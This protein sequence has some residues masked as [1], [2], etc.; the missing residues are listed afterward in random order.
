MPKKSFYL[1]MTGA[2]RIAAIA[3]LLALG[4]VRLASREESLKRDRTGLNAGL[5]R[6]KKSMNAL[7][8][9]GKNHG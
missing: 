5:K 3:E 8:L 9:K 7:D 2:E 1:N 6:S 4:I